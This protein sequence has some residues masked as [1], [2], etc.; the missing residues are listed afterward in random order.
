MLQ[1]KRARR[2]ASPCANFA[3]TALICLCDAVPAPA[4]GAGRFRPQHASN[5]IAPVEG[6]P[7]LV[8]D[9]NNQYAL[10]RFNVHHVV[11][12]TAKDHATRFREIRTTV[13]GEGRDAGNG[14]FYL[15]DKLLSQPS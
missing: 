6:R 7:P 15:C 4:R 10:I 3:S 14:A 11:G 2:V 13:I 12:E 1:G 8:G 9:R 5:A